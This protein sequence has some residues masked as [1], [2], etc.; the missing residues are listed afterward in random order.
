MKRAK[1]IY[2]VILAEI[3]VLNILYVRYWP[4]WLLL[5]ALLFPVVL[6]IMLSVG[7]SSL[8]VSY[9]CESESVEKGDT[10]RFNILFSNKSHMT[11]GAADIFFRYREAGSDI[12]KNEKVS[13]YIG[14]K[15]RTNVEVSVM[16]EHIGKV[17]L[18][19]KKYVFYD[20]LYLLK[21]KKKVS[22]TTMS[23]K[24]YP[25]LYA[26]MGLSDYIK[27]KEITD[28][29]TFSVTRPG[30]DPSE[31][32]EVREYKDGDRISRIH[33]KL[34][35]KMDK[36]IVKDFSLPVDNSD[37]IIFENRKCSPDI[38]DNMF[39][40]LM[41]LMYE[42]LSSETSFYLVYWDKDELRNIYIKEYE[43]VADA[44]GVIL[45]CEEYEGNKALD[46]LFVDKE[47]DN[48]I[49][50]WIVDS[51]DEVSHAD[52]S[53]SLTLTVRSSEAVYDDTVIDIRDWIIYE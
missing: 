49:V 18:E 17:V 4:L 28:S 3:C 37:H 1:I 11:V 7:L 20:P 6:Y 19:M 5:V 24:V 45:E 2:F 34:S 53:V 42:L 31:V 26:N 52:E 16:C 10:A 30:D 32:F 29:D 13:V 36:Y 48:C 25:K 47:I 41:T 22:D 44:V 14:A 33:W 51:T 38:R 21:K 40:A 39:E 12:W 27:H 35:N 46:N 8:S 23:V 50:Y 9:L 15:C 43:D